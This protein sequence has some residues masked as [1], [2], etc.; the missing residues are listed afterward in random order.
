[1]AENSTQPTMAAAKCSVRTATTT[2]PVPSRT[3]PVSAE[4][5]R[6]IARKAIAGAEAWR[7]VAQSSIRQGSMHL[8]STAQVEA[9]ATVGNKPANYGH[10]TTKTKIKSFKRRLKME[11]NVNKT[12]K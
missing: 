8:L 3:A 12:T 7:D 2:L 5:A 6:P 1:M 11:S 9:A 10:S 4:T